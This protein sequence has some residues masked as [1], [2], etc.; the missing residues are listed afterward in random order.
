MQFR[1]QHQRPPKLRSR[2]A[3]HLAKSEA[4]F[5]RSELK[6]VPK[7]FQSLQN[8]RFIR[9]ARQRKVSPAREIK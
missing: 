1:R 8:G 5:G 3:C 9:S 2:T 6:S 7:Q 4:L